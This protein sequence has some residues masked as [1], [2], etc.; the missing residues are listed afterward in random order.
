MTLNSIL[1][2]LMIILVIFELHIPVNLLKLANIQVKNDNTSE[3]SNNKTLQIYSSVAFDPVP[4]VR[5]IDT[6]F[7]FFY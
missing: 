1:A 4:N 3:K 6:T 7:F 2:S 5:V